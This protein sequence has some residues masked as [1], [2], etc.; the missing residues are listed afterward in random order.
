MQHLAL[1]DNGHGGEGGGDDEAA[2]PRVRNRSRAMQGPSSAWVAKADDK[3]MGECDCDCDPALGCTD[4]LLA[5]DWMT[6]FR[7]TCSLPPS[8]LLC[9]TGTFSFP[10]CSVSSNSPSPPG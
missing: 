10:R 8:T 1:G 6:Y 2:H 5:R 7:L 3:M 9:P 4:A